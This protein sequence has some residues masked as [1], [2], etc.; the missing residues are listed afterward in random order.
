MGSGASQDDSADYFSPSPAEN[1]KTGGLPTI[2]STEDIQVQLCRKADHSPASLGLSARLHICL[3]GSAM[4]FT[5]TV[6]TL[7][8]SRKVLQHCGD[9]LAGRILHGSRS[10]CAL[11]LS[12]ENLSNCFHMLQKYKIQLAA[13]GGEGQLVSPFAAGQP[14][15]RSN[16]Q[17]PLCFLSRDIWCIDN[18]ELR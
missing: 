12:H 8:A 17:L 6:F 4:T 15:V 13:S 16:H 9:S 2:C 7:K 3:R 18:F 5:V 14:G 10:C 11:F 1:L